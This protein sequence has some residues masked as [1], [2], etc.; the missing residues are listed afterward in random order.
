MA[1]VVKAFNLPVDYVL[2]DM[3]YANAILYCASLPSYDRPD[4]KGA[5]NGTYNGDDVATNDIIKK[6]ALNST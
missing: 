3:S 1:G 6:L 5:D 2:Y 4:K